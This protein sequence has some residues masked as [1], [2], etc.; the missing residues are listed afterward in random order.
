M[1]TSK[2]YTKFC[3]SVINAYHLQFVRSSKMAK[4]SLVEVVLHCAVS[5]F[6]IHVYTQTMKMIKKV[7]IL[8]ILFKV[9]QF[10]N[11][12]RLK[13]CDF[14]PHLSKLGLGY[15]FALDVVIHSNKQTGP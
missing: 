1:T 10:E 3:S 5:L 11:A 9:G 13:K 7:Q 15:R 12:V 8:K 6:A 14:K 2:L 4:I